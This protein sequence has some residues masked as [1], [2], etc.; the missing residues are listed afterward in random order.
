MKFG[1]GYE[2]LMMV[3]IA[4][5]LLCGCEKRK[6]ES[7]NMIAGNTKEI[8]DTNQETREQW[9]KGY[10]LPLDEAEQEEAATQC[11]EMMKKIQ[12]IYKSADK[13]TASNAVLQ[14]E[15]MLGMQ[16]AMFDLL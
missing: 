11:K 1:K 9:E 5:C 10:N 7:E 12:D 13:G 14:D 4:G 15:T 16:K 6:S 3:L 2:I 8:K